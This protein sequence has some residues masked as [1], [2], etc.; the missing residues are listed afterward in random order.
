MKQTKFFTGAGLD[1]QSAIENGYEVQAKQFVD[2]ER[3]AGKV[4]S[5]ETYDVEGLLKDSNIFYVVIKLEYT[6]Q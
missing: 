4:V 1:L 6:S 5:N 3:I 2:Q